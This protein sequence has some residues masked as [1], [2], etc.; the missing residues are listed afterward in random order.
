MG[1]R[2]TLFS[3][4]GFYA[5]LE[6]KAGLEMDLNF[7]TLKNYWNCFF[8]KTRRRNNKF[9]IKIA[10]QT[11]DGIRLKLMATMFSYSLS[12]TLVGTS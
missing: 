3:F 11:S 12:R 1:V 8:L 7:E 5:S 2:S 4:L 6:F 9:G 10:N